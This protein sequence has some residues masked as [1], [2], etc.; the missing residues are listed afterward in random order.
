MSNTRTLREEGGREG[1]RKDG[2]RGRG[3]G[4]GEGED[5]RRKVVKGGRRCECSRSW[6][7]EKVYVKGGEHREEWREMAGRG[8]AKCTGIITVGQTKVHLSNL[9]CTHCN[10]ITTRD[11]IHE[12]DSRVES[13]H[14][15]A[16]RLCALDI[17]LHVSDRASRPSPSPLVR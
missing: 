13:N 10:N 14:K 3:E 12:C 9:Q 15:C 17:K 2:K 6:K 7:E 5:R 11:V 4:R 16:W 8:M 1:E